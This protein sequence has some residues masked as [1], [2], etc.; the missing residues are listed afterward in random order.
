MDIIFVRSVLSV[1]VFAVFLGIV[2]W[3]YAP[4][5]KQRFDK[6]AM[7]IFKDIEQ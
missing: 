2:W 1:A 5:R 4:R 6:D 3:A 7:S